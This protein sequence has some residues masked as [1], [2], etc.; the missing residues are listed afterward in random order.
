MHI[1]TITAELTR[2]LERLEKQIDQG[3]RSDSDEVS[4][5]R[6]AL[7]DFLWWIQR[8]EGSM[9]DLMKDAEILQDF[10]QVS[11]VILEGI[12]RHVLY[13]QRVGHF[14]TAVLTNN[15][16]EAF[17]RADEGN[18]KTMFQIVSYCHNQ[19][20]GCC[21][22]TPEKVKAWTEMDP[23]DFPPVEAPTESRE[24]ERQDREIIWGSTKFMIEKR[25]Q[26]LEKEGG[27]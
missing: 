12:N 4:N 15:L 20:P 5:K 26:E 10:G 9:E 18:Q 16:R 24:R 19:I 21:W 3:F 25:L 6:S 7:Q 23:K 13:H 8:Q 11:Q 1:K 22:G 17:A 2:L 14:L 27:E